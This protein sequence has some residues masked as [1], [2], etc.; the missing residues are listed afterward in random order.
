MVVR[1]VVVAAVTPTLAVPRLHLWL[2][3]IARGWSARDTLADL[4]AVTGGYRIRATKAL[5]HVTREAL[6]R[7][8]FLSQLPPRSPQLT[9]PGMLRSPMTECLSK[10]PRIITSDSMDCLEIAAR[11]IRLSDHPEGSKNGQSILGLALDLRFHPSP[12][13]NQ[14]G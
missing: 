7:S 9:H 3:G 4:P 2:R 8:V 11:L 10:W 14:R 6:M 1:T 13:R 5:R 12:A